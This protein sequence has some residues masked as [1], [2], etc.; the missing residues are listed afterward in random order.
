MKTLATDPGSPAKQTAYM[1]NVCKIFTAKIPYNNNLSSQMI[2]LWFGWAMVVLQRDKFVSVSN[3]LLLQC[4]IQSIVF[5]LLF[6]ST[7]KYALASPP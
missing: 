3:S 4:S 2:S 5:F 7:S 6:H 1:F